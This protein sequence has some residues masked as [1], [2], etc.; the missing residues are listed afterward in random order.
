MEKDI[1]ILKLFGTKSR[2][3]VEDI[4]EA[5]YKDFDVKIENKDR[6]IES[7]KYLIDHC[8]AIADWLFEKM[9]EK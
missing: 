2:K 1:A 6:I 9:K 8:Q 4:V 3:G 5:M 7:H